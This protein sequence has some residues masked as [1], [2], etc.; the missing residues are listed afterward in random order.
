MFFGTKLMQALQ[1]VNLYRSTN[2]VRVG[3]VSAGLVMSWD[4]DVHHEGVF[5]FPV[6]IF[7]GRD[8]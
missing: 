4:C 6:A 7:Q 5:P 8:Q 2:Y 3:V 1:G